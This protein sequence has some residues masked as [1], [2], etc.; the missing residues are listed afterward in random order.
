MFDAVYEGKVHKTIINFILMMAIDSRVIVSVV[1]RLLAGRHWI[2]A[3]GKIINI[4]IPY[5]KHY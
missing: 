2:P 3:N 4:L 5:K 1:K